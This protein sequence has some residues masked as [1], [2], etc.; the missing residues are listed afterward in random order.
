MRVLLGVILFCLGV[1]VFSFSSL[2]A[3]NSSTGLARGMWSGHYSGPDAKV[4][5][6]TVT[7]DGTGAGFIEYSTMKCG[8]KL[9]FA[10]KSGEDYSYRETITHGRAKCGAAGQVE[11]IADGEQLMWTRTAGGK[12]MSATLLSVD[13]P[14]ADDC[15]SCELNYDQNYDACYTISNGDDRQ[16]CLDK[17]QDNLQ[18]C[19]GACQE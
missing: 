4:Y 7:L 12:K 16:K 10:R 11:L 6:V 3:Q 8:G 18:N 5:H 1:C 9:H 13:M 15:T 19:E 14:D 2:H 17:A